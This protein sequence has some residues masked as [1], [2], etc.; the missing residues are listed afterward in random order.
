[1]NISLFFRNETSAPRHSCYPVD[2]LG[3]EE[4]IHKPVFAMF[5]VETC[6]VYRGA[7][8]LEKGEC[9]A[10]PVIGSATVTSPRYIARQ[11]RTKHFNCPEKISRNP[12][13]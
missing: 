2:A 3:I 7:A 4:E 8:L 11:L 9:K 13:I 12:D 10:A 6:P 5:Y 1:M